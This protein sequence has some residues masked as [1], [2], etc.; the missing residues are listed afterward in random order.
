MSKHWL[1]GF[2][3]VFALVVMAYVGCSSNST[4]PFH[5]PPPVSQTPQPGLPSPTPLSI[6]TTVPLAMGTALPV[7]GIGG[8]SGTFQI[9]A[10]NAPA[11]TSVKLTSYRSAPA[12]APP[13]MAIKHSPAGLIRSGRMVGA[14]GNAIFWVSQQYSQP[15]SFQGFATTAWQVPATYASGSLALETFDGMTGTLLDTEFDTSIAGDIVTFPGSAAAFPVAH[16]DTYWWELITGKPTPP[17]SPSPTPTS[18]VSPSPTP[19]VLSLQITSGTPP[20]GVAG[21]SYGTV[22]T[23]FFCTCFCKRPACRHTLRWTAFD[24]SASGGTAPYSWSWSAAPGSSLPPGLNIQAVPVGHGIS[25]TPT[26][27]GT[28]RVIVTVTDSGSPQLHRSASYTINITPPPPVMIT[29]SPSSPQLGIPYSFSLCATGGDGSYTWSWTAAT[30]STLPPGLSLVGA[31]ITGTPTRLGTYKVVVTA[32]DTETPPKRATVTWAITVVLPPSPLPVTAYTVPT[33]NSG[34]N[35]ITSGL[36]YIW[37]T[38]SNSGRIARSTTNG[39]ITEYPGAV[40]P[41]GSTIG[42]DHNLWFVN[43]GAGPNGCDLLG[44][45]NVASGTVTNFSMP[46]AGQGHCL[47]V[48]AAGPDGNI[49]VPINSDSSTI[50]TIAVVRTDGTVI[51]TYPIHSNSYPFGNDTFGADGNFWVGEPSINKIAKVTRTGAV[52]EYSLSSGTVGV[53]KGPDGNIWCTLSDNNIARI[54]P[55][56]GV[57]EF[58][59]TTPSSGLIWIATGPDGNLWF[60]ENSANQIGRITPSGKITEFRLLTPDSAAAVI[61]AGPD[62]DMWFTQ[63]NTNDIAK[64]K[65]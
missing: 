65:P 38:E 17:P 31:A 59:V 57:T 16:G 2:V 23:T 54:T 25:G 26:A 18:T 36:G 10:N 45:F 39:S 64:F 24:L 43:N 30:G 60:V 20:T 56:G 14:V 53:A 4:V 58:P 8:F 5:T 15:F 9:A 50:A 28:Y 35:G 41:Y 27:I 49:W 46:P 61:T 42:P 52:T 7:P 32:Q 34:L 48:P 33:V 1:H 3:C 62:G 11:G 44:R 63:S 47:S 13:P 29:C 6:S 40:H 21:Q 55:G 37:F 22:H 19:S 12:A 51:A